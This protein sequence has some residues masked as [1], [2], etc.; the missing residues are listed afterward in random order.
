MSLQMDQY[1]FNAPGQ[2]TASSPEYI[3][4][5]YGNSTSSAPSYYGLG[6]SAEQ[7]NGYGMKAS[8]SGYAPA[9]SSGYTTFEGD[10]SG[11]YAQYTGNTSPHSSPPHSPRGGA[12][13]GTNHYGSG[14]NVE[15]RASQPQTG[16]SARASFPTQNTN[17]G[18]INSLPKA[19]ET[20]A[21][22]MNGTS[23]HGFTTRHSRPAPATLFHFG[24]IFLDWKL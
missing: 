20:P 11:M 17:A 9:S 14:V 7:M 24:N 22:N 16:Y 12:F 13:F 21:T 15:R 23:S 10:Q 2:L 3:P 5:S 6:Q 18:Y 1:A 4:R 19:F 8:N